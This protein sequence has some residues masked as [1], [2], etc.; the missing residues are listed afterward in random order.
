MEFVA[1]L[2]RSDSE[3]AGHAVLASELPTN[4]SAA[5]QP[6]RA[7]GRPRKD[8]AAAAAAGSA[9]V[10]D[11]AVFV[12]A[13]GALVLRPPLAA[14]S[15][16]AA[17]AAAVPAGPHTSSL[18]RLLSFS[19]YYYGD[20]PGSA[21]DAPSPLFDRPAGPAAK[22][23]RRAAAD[24]AALS[25]VPAAAPSP[26]DTQGSFPLLSQ[27]SVISRS[28]DDAFVPRADTELSSAY[29][30]RGDSLLGLWLSSASVSSAL[31]PL[32]AVQ[33]AALDQRA[34]S[35][36]TEE[37]EQVASDREEEGEED[38][39]GAGERLGRARG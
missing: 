7:R 25:W 9:S 12:D 30:P 6:K 36:D 4:G 18:A 22:R 28:S 35:Q 10:E 1:Q 2:L 29:L 33:E 38:G 24:A 16:A 26:E 39:A 15:T 17:A 3:P 34:S 21:R 11:T 27:I 8:G 20:G 13:A 32:G 19:R 5:Q 31:L 37:T 23:A 14:P